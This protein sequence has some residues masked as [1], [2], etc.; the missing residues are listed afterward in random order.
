MLWNSVIFG[1][2]ESINYS[3]ILLNLVYQHKM[4]HWHLGKFNDET[5]MQY[6]GRACQELMGYLESFKDN[7]DV[8]DSL[9]S[10]LNGEVQLRWGEEIAA[11]IMSYINVMSLCSSP[12]EIKNTCV[13]IALYYALLRLQE[14]HQTGSSSVILSDTHP[15]VYI[16]EKVVERLAAKEYGNDLTTFEATNGGV[17]FIVQTYFNI[18]LQ[19]LSNPEI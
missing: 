17:W 4:T 2:N 16:R 15:P 12:A 5:R 9:H 19:A 13:S 7:A 6:I 1:S 3:Y 10:F 18:V 14:F 11:A 8:Y